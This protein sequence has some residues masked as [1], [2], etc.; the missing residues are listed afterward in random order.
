M[1]RLARMEVPLWSGMMPKCLV[2]QRQKGCQPPRRSRRHHLHPYQS[3]RALT[4]L[5][6]LLDCGVE[7]PGLLLEA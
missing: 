5:L 2:G 3:P 7:V 4:H 6:L 1:H